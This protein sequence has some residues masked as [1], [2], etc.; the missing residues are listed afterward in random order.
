MTQSEIKEI[1][2][3]GLKAYYEFLSNKPNGGVEEISI[4]QIERVS[5][6]TFKLRIDK[7]LFDPDTVCFLYNGRFKKFYTGDSIAIKIYDNDQRVIIVRVT[8]E[9]IPLMSDLISSNWKVIIDLKF[10]VQ[11]VIDWFELNGNRIEFNSGKRKNYPFDSSVIPKGD[12]NNPSEE[13]K[14]AIN[15]M[16]LY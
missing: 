7:K 8:N 9:V 14:E 5:E 15:T 2:I 16:E 10:L 3:N 1:C 11:R 6:N 4:R 12:G 13:Q